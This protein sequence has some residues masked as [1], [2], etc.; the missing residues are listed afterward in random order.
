MSWEEKD[1]GPAVHVFQGREDLLA[2]CD[3][4]P[5]VAFQVEE[6]LACDLVFEHAEPALVQCFNLEFQEVFL[7]G[8]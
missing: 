3:L 4:I 7:L 1:D 6:F 8:R 5:E 2:G